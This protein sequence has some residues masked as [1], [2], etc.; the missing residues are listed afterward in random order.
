MQLWL[1][2]LQVSSIVFV[3]LLPMHDKL[4]TCIYS[5]HN[6]VQGGIVDE[7]H[8]FLWLDAGSDGL[9]LYPKFLF[10]VGG[11]VHQ[12]QW[13]EVLLVGG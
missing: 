7:G 6:P 2:L 5:C 3:L 13:V 12:G 4:E 8:C 1:V 10:L 11:C 9:N